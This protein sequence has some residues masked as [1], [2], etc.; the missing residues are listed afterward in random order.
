[1]RLHKA[2]ISVN[3]FFESKMNHF[4]INDSLPLYELITVSIATSIC[5]ITKLVIIINAN[6]F[7]AYKIICY[8]SAA[9]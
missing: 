6:T 4:S 3:S 1:M 9:K 5:R 2:T 8:S 7:N